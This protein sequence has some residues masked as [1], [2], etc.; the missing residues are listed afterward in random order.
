MSTPFLHPGLRRTLPTL[1]PLVLGSSFALHQHF[2][3]QPFFTPFRPVLCDSPDPLTKIT[4]DLKQ[5]FARKEEPTI[6]QSGVGLNPKT[7]R[8]ISLGS[9]LGVLGGLGVSVFSKPLAILV[10][11]GVVVVQVRLHVF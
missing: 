6:Q 11:L 7:I 1:T 2:S 4:S 9:V 10:G 5:S 8:Q 3:P